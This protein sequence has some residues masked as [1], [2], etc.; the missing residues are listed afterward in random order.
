MA[1]CRPEAIL[2]FAN[3]LEEFGPAADAEALYRRVAEEVA[4]TLLEA[5]VE[6][7]NFERRHGRLQR[8]MQIYEGALVRLAPALDA[9]GVHA[10]VAASKA[11]SADDFAFLSLH[12]GRFLQAVMGELWRCVVGARRKMISARLT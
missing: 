12:Y 4:P 11:A 9:N 3:F 10:G 7:A 2:E 8:S 6:Y 1:I 5:I